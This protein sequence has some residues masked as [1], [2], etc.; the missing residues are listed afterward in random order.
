MSADNNN[1]T[2]RTTIPVLLT[3]LSILMWANDSPAQQSAGQP[4]PARESSEPTSENRDSTDSRHIER[5]GEVSTQEWEMDLA[6]PGAATGMPSADGDYALSDEVQNQKLQKLLSA[7]ARNP[8]N[9]AVLTELNTMLAALLGQADTLMDAGSLD[10]A[11]QIMAVITSINPNLPGLGPAQQKVLR[12]RAAAELLSAGNTAL[13][14]R[15]LVEPEGNNAAYFYNRALAE[16]PRSRSAQSGLARV[17]EGLVQRALESARELDFEM[18][19]EWLQRASGIRESQSLVEDGQRA[20]IAFKQEYAR[21]LEQKAIEA[22]DSGNFTLADFYIIDLI[23]LGGEQARVESLRIRLEEARL[24]GGFQPGQ[25]ISDAFL[26]SQDKAPDIVIIAA[27]SFLLGSDDDSEGAHDNE[28]P[29][30]R[31]NIER[32]FGMGAREVTVAQFR[33]FIQRSRHLS[34]AER[35]GESSIYDETAGRLNSRKGIDWEYDYRGKK[36]GE[37]MPV[38]H[39]NWHDAQ[40]YVQWL[41]RETGKR[42]RLPSEAEYEYVARA[43]GTKAYWWGDGTPTE[44]VENLTGQRDLSPGKRSWGTSFKKY[45]DGHWGPAPVGSFSANPMGIYDIAGNVSEF[46]EDCW[47]QNYIMAPVDGSAWVNPGCNRRVVRGGYWASAPEKSRAAYRIAAKP[48]TYGP[49]V[50]FRVARD[51]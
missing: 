40:A 45:G 28:Q 33:L 44:V 14:S 30:H 5:L 35:A 13:E 11:T 51:L 21:Q 22:M 26:R 3:L 16:D 29:R 43:G 42:Y 4:D 37:D 36:A 9:G 10:E 50:G 47:H 1:L 25:V 41:A 38:M 2:T 34:D 19:G 32:G 23:A 18:A 17:Q 31:V 27:G 48:E 20:V 8:G 6:L 7:L 49:V 39:V 15:R 46:V 24:Y 12:L